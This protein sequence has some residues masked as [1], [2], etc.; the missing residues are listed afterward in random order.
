VTR[1]DRRKDQNNRD[2]AHQL[3]KRESALGELSGPFHF[4]R[5]EITFPSH[6]FN[7][8]PILPI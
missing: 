6:L 8:N 3:D 7:S 4:S 5:F 2:H 1:A